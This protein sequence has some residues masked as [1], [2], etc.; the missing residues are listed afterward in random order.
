M[1][2]RGKIDKNDQGEGKGE[3]KDVKEDKHTEIQLDSIKWW[4]GVGFADLLK[5]IEFILDQL[6][7]E[8]GKKA[9]WKSVCKTYQAFSRVLSA[10]DEP[11]KELTETLEADYEEICKGIFQ[12][13]VDVLNDE[14][15]L[16]QEQ[17]CDESTRFWNLFWDKLV[18]SHGDHFNVFAKEQGGVYRTRAFAVQSNF[19]A[20]EK[21]ASYEEHIVHLQDDASQRF[22]DVPLAREKKGWRSTMAHVGSVRRKRSHESTRYSSPSVEAVVEKKTEQEEQ[23]NH[24][25]LIKLAYR[26]HVLVVRLENMIRFLKIY[27]FEMEN[28]NRYVATCRGYELLLQVFTQNLY[29]YLGDEEKGISSDKYAELNARYAQIGQS[30]FGLFVVMLEAETSLS[31]D[32]KQQCWKVFDTEF[33]NARHFIAESMQTAADM[34]QVSAYVKEVFD[35]DFIASYLTSQQT[36]SEEGHP[37]SALFLRVRKPI[38][39]R[40]MIQRLNQ[41]EEL[42]E[43]Q[44][45]PRGAPGHSG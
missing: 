15:S 22:D 32:E 43:P 24:V 26:V 19:L 23:A 13:F 33:A 21:A 2:Q 29:T 5:K 39:P 35:K 4:P 45:T 28:K 31:Q 12:L 14:C 1:W 8:K 41:D 20:M 34:G 25:D 36:S 37:G 10:M 9:Q 40:G 18:N 3:D 44:D 16:S 11:K 7:F 38:T 17:K 27:S 42:E 30:I 6:R